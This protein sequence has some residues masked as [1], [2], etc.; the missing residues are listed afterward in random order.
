MR[1]PDHV[2]TKTDQLNKLGYETSDVSL[3]TL[4]KWIIFLFMFIGITS[5]VT[6]LIYLIF[7][8]GVKNNDQTSAST[9]NKLGPDQ[10]A[11]QV[12]PRIDLKEFRAE[13]EAKLDKYGWVDKNAGTVHIPVDT[14]IEKIAASGTL[15][16]ADPG[17]VD[18]KPNPSVDNNA[19]GAANPAPG[20]AMPGGTGG[21]PGGPAPGGGMVNGVVPGGEAQSSGSPRSST[22]PSD[23][24]TANN[25]AGRVP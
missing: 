19:N 4:V 25:P 13:E 6:W 20:P 24:G 1:K 22:N 23:A 15:P 8:P 3:P 7:V 14:M 10:P 5:V 17:A 18:L 12:H 21:P 2:N 11:L 16:K 9:V